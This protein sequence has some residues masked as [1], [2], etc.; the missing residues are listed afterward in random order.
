LDDITTICGE[1]ASVLAFEL[2]PGAEAASP[3]LTSFGF[4]YSK[5]PAQSTR[6][7]MTSEPRSTKATYVG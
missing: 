4:G 1:W 7:Q 2:C 5:C 6:K 3:G